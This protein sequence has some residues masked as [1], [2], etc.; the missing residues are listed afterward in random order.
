MKKVMVIGLIIFAFVLSASIGGHQVTSSQE[1]FRGDWTAKVKDTDKLMLNL[2]MDVDKEGRKHFSNWGFT[3]PLRDFS[4][5]NPNANSQIQ[6]TLN[7]EA[8]TVL[9]DG[10]FKDGKG[11]GDFRFTPNTSFI[12]TMQGL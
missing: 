11:V 12:S 3:L 7:R 4:G 1:Q 5:L 2:T 8:G 9:F 6:F 10:L